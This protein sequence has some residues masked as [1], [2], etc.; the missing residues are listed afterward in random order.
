MKN[1]D[2]YVTRASHSEQ[3]LCVAIC[4]IDFFSQIADSYGKPAAEYIL[5]RAMHQIRS[6]LRSFDFVE[7]M[8][9]NHEFLM[10]FG[11]EKS[12]AVGIFE[13]VRLSIANTPFYYEDTILHVTITCGITVF[14]PPNDR[15]GS[16]DIF[17]SA[18]AALEMAKDNGRN[19]V[20]CL[21]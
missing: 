9:K 8:N 19:K 21:P 15:R 12:N 7:S 2:V 14:D 13:R 17:I 3:P 5:R 20:I 4:E 10:V 11:C 6:E 1:L 16:D 18:D